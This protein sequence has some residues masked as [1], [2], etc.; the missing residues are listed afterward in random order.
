MITAVVSLLAVIPVWLKFKASGDIED[1]V[2]APVAG[3]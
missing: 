3:S 2:A 1:E